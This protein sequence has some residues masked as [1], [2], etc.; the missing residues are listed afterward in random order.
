[1]S[2][3]AYAIYELTTLNRYNGILPKE[4]LSGEY[5]STNR[6]ILRN[7]WYRSSTSFSGRKLPQFAQVS[8]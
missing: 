2:Y 4:T 6:D 1:M 7:F 5:Y 3:C 8:G